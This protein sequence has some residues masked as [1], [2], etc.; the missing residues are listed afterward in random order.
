MNGSEVGM[1]KDMVRFPAELSLLP[2][3][4]PKNG[5]CQ[6]SDKLCLLVLGVSR[7]IQTRAFYCEALFKF[8]CGRGGCDIGGG[9]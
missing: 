2:G 8:L 6:A 4:S 9:C 1:H 3:R 7:Q 5:K